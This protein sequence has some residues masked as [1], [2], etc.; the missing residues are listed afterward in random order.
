MH[1]P[2]GAG[3]GSLRN[4]GGAQTYIPVSGDLE[5]DRET[6]I[7]IWDGILGPADK[8]PEKFDAFYLNC[9]F[10]RPILQML[11]HRPSNTAVGVVAAGPRRMLWH[12]KEVS[13]G[14]VAHLAVLPAHRKVKPAVTMQRALVEA[15]RGHF[16]L[17]YGLPSVMGAAMGRLAG[18]KPLGYLIR[19][20]KVLRYEHYLQRVL[21]RPLAFVAGKSLN[22]MVRIHAC[23]R[24]LANRRQLYCAWSDSVDP[25]MQA[26][27]DHS[28]HGD[29]LTAIRDVQMLRWR[30]DEAPAEAKTRFFLVSQTAGAPLLAW[31]SCEINPRLTGMLTVTDFW[32]AAGGP[33]MD[34]AH[35]RALCQRARVEGFHAMELLFTSSEQTVASWH[36]VGFI[37]RT[38]NPAFGGS[39]NPTF[40]SDELRNHLHLTYLDQD[41]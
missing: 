36:A 3:P 41:G 7:G 16:D 39:L 15:C 38:R 22:L 17:M 6:V 2:N 29:D 35:I 40:T 11:R 30:F 1:E 21:P 14:V 8:L 9:P 12:G 20:V 26:V 25:R 4:S 27:W 32:S 23:A 37:E 18:Y 13:A 19:Y 31:F 24:R 28:P 5:R 33:V 10:G 34:R